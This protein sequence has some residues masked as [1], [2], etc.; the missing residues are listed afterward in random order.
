M[1]E[2]CTVSDLHEA[3]SWLGYK[4]SV[5][6]VQKNLWKGEFFINTGSPEECLNQ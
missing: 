5:R 4:V 2:K 6:M 3:V 1:P